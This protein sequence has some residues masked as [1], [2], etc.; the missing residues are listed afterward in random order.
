M[1]AYLENVPCDW[2]HVTGSCEGIAGALPRV[3]KLGQAS[4]SSVVLKS[5][6]PTRP[7]SFGVV[8]RSALWWQRILVAPGLEGVCVVCVFC[9]RRAAAAQIPPHVEV[10]KTQS[11]NFLSRTVCCLPNYSSSKTNN[12]LL[13][14][15]GIRVIFLFCSILIVIFTFTLPC[16]CLL[17]T[18]VSFSF[19][20]L[21][22]LS[23]PFTFS[24]IFSLS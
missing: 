24:F 5:Y 3:F 22:L 10:I 11:S 15:I 7:V 20:C 18:N 2:I 12:L 19:D 16:C 13:P 23:F 17:F 9:V 21:F 4:C 6:I 8:D 1:C 14:F